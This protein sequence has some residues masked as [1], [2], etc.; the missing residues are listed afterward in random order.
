[1]VIVWVLIGWVTV[2]L[3]T[4]AIGQMWEAFQQWRRRS[5]KPMPAAEPKKF[6]RL[7]G[8]LS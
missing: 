4:A 8:W 7:P 1:M 6:L 5:R 2:A 3:I